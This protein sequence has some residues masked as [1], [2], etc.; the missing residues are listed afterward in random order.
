MPPPKCVWMHREARLSSDEVE[1]GRYWSFDAH[2]TPGSV[3]DVNS[4][5]LST[6][7]NIPRT[8]INSGVGQQQGTVGLLAHDICNTSVFSAIRQICRAQK[9]PSQ[10]QAENVT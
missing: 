5:A 7:G 1:V 8:R 2:E 3:T 9:E 6:W 10:K 4:T